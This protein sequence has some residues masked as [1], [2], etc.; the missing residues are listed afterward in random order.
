[1]W[2]D[3]DGKRK[4]PYKSPDFYGVTFSAL[5]S[6]GLVLM[7]DPLHTNNKNATGCVVGKC[8]HGGAASLNGKVQE[9]DA[10]VSVNGKSTA[11]MRLPKIIQF[12]GKA[13][14]PLN[15]RFHRAHGSGRYGI[16]D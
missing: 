2:V 3:K 11:D 1:M 15:L 10:L 6:I 5:G 4:V 8:V 7:Q 9:G 13:P 12:I 14:R 16:A